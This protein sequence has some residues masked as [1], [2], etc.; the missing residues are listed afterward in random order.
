MQSADLTCPR[1]HCCVDL[2]IEPE[3]VLS[4]ELAKSH[5]NIPLQKLLFCTFC[6]FRIFVIF[7]CPHTRPTRCWQAGWV[8]VILCIFFIFDIFRNIKNGGVYLLHVCCIFVILVVQKGGGVYSRGAYA[9]GTCI[10]SIFDIF[11]YHAYSSYSSYLLYIVYCTYSAYYAY[12]TSYNMRIV[13]YVYNKNISNMLNMQNKCVSRQP[14][15][16]Y[17]PVRI[18]RICEIWFQYVYSV[19]SAYFVTYPA[20]NKALLD[21]LRLKKSNT[22]QGHICLYSTLLIGH[23]F[24]NR[25]DD[26]RGNENA[27][28]CT[29]F[30]A[31]GIQRSQETRLYFAYSVY[32]AYTA[33]SCCEF[34]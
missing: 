22:T 8:N 34:I 18:C 25:Y 4:I 16:T 1:H 19:Y 24:L 5:K 26:Q 7:F 33:Y 10:F 17:A 30:S 6:I 23:T 14:G 29:C 15:H 28:T 27:R 3:V 12:C 9:K 31:G 13:R 11:V 21:T 32:C 20:Q 2:H